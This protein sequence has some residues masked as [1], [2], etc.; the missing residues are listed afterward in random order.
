MAEPDLQ[1]SV[2]HF[3]HETLICSK[4]S[5]IFCIRYT[6]NLLEELN[7]DIL[8]IVEFYEVDRILLEVHVVVFI[9][10]VCVNLRLEYA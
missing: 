7:K 3:L 4:V 5:V 9:S 1:L 2:C 6:R 8:D 10:I